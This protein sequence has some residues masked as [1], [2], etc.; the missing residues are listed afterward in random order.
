MKILGIQV[1]HNSSACL[2][3][4]EKLLYFNQEERISRFKNQSGIPWE[5][6]SEI[7][8][9][10]SEIDKLIITG[11]SYDSDS[12]ACIYHFIRNN[13]GFKINDGWF[14][15]FK[16]HHICHAY[17]SF[18]S[19]K[20]EESLVFV[21]DG[22]GSPFNLSDGTVA[23]ETTTVF[24]VSK[25]RGMKTIY[26]KLYRE[27]SITDVDLNS[28][29][30][31]N[32]EY[33]FNN[34]KIAGD[35]Q[36]IIIDILSN[37]YDVGPYYETI[38][39]YLGFNPTEC[40]KLMGLHSYGKGDGE[41]SN[42][43]YDDNQFK[44][45]VNDQNIKSQY[46]F[47]ESERLIDFCYETQRGLEHI[48]LNLI[49]KI[50]DRNISKNIVLT[51]GVALNIVA[52]SFIRKNIP[53]DINLYVEPICG[54]EG[55]CLGAVQYYIYEQTSKTATIPDTLY[56]CGNNP[57]Y[58]FELFEN[59]KVFDDVDYSFV[60]NLLTSGNIVSLFQGRAEA[61]PRA[62]GNR[63]L[64]FDPRIKNGKDI[65]NG[66]K[67]REPFRPFACSVLLEESHN[68]FDMS[69]IEESL[70]MMYSFDVL[71]GVEEIIPSVVH[72]D[73]T[74][75]IQTVTEKQNYHFYNLIKEFDRQTNVPIL[76]NTSFNLAGQPIV[77]TLNDALFTLRSS[78]I[79]YLYLPE[80]SKVIFVPNKN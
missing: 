52:N 70:H 33:T 2:F 31:S 5:C 40:G 73:K 26:K 59:E 45:N 7:K 49:N 75:R 57:L 47:L 11:Y 21:S 63:S 13:L 56:V 54:D 43:L 37:G 23:Y 78:E 42:L 64:L 36:N 53:K 25:K 68:W 77:E 20:F 19:S 67:R 39:Q 17:K 76:F 6:L 46:E 69:L 1:H 79:E 8:K 66:V 28:I 50:L 71:P 74:S 35:N 38:T 15:Y 10:T 72:V 3:D 80:I 60:C 41:I 27:N 55:N 9:I 61:G 30:L 32:S 16:P 62:L 18:L 14:S 34:V 51:G 12:Y 22:R 44:I 24:H 58:E 48:Q 65:V 4:D 29:K